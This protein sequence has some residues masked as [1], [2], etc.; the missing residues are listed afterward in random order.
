MAMAIFSRNAHG[1]PRRAAAN[2]E[3]CSVHSLSGDDAVAAFAL[4][5]EEFFVGLADQ[6]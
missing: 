1:E 4:G 3:P 6:V 2:F 5:L